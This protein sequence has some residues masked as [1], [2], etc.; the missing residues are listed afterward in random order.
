MA[1][2]RSHIRDAVL[3]LI[4]GKHGLTEPFCFRVTGPGLVTVNRPHIVFP[5]PGV[6][7]PLAVNLYGRNIQYLLGVLFSS[8]LQHI[9]RSL[10]MSP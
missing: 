1:Q 2:T 4:G 10:Y 7:F 8:K 9:A 5:N 6:F 3:L